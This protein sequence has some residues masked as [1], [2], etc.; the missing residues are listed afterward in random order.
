M[1][2]TVE[3]AKAS[4]DNVDKRATGYGECSWFFSELLVPFR[5]R[6]PGSGGTAESR[7]KLFP[8]P[9]PQPA[10]LLLHILEIPPPESFSHQ[11]LL[12]ILPPPSSRLPYTSPSCCSCFQPGS[13]PHSILSWATRAL[14]STCKSH[15]ASLL[16]QTLPKLNLPIA[17]VSER[18]HRKPGSMQEDP[19]ACGKKG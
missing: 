11:P 18:G 17:V 2:L 9:P 1:E 6:G 19:P 14:F 8:P 13:H 15:S 5:D 4:D 10:H 12:S 7:M 16:L 3:R